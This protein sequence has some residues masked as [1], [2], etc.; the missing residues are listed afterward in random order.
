MENNSESQNKN[1]NVLKIYEEKNYW[2]WC[3][4]HVTSNTAALLTLKQAL[5]FID[6]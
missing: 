5:S 6:T 1:N 3:E 4:C 2:Q